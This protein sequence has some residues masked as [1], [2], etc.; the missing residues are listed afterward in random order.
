MAKAS[1]PIIRG[2]A[3]VVRDDGFAFSVAGILTGLRY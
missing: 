3:F 1:S 2:E